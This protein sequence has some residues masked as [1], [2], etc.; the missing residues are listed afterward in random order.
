M[1]MKLKYFRSNMC[2]YSFFLEFGES[3][4]ANFVGQVWVAL[5]FQPSADAF[6]S[7]LVVFARLDDP[8]EAFGS[9]DAAEPFRRACVGL[10]VLVDFVELD[11]GAG[12]FGGDGS[13]VVDDA[14]VL[15]G[16]ACI[17]ID[18]AADDVTAVL[19][20]FELEGHDVGYFRC[21]EVVEDVG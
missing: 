10:V 14:G 11:V 9:L 15:F 12:I 20:V 16:R 3:L 7:G 21:V 1:R 6:N 5:V 13:D 17:W 4:A 2:S 8:A 18:L 19:V